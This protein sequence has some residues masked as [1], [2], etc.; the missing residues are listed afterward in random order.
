MIGI[1]CLTHLNLIDQCAMVEGGKKGTGLVKFILPFE[2]I[3]TLCV[4]C[5][6]LYIELLVILFQKYIPTYLNLLAG[7]V[8]WVL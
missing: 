7:E 4:L 1:L 5:C 2:I 6:L 3:L 8:L